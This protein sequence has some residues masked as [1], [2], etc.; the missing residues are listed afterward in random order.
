MSATASQI[1]NLTIVYSIVHSDTDQRK[2]QSSAS[3][4]FV[5]GIHRGPVNSPHKWPVT[6]K[7]FSFDDVIMAIQIWWTS[8]IVV[9]KLLAIRSHQTFVHATTGHWSCHVQ[10]FES[11]A[12]S[13]F[14]SEKIQTKFPLNLNCYGKPV[15][16]MN[17][18][19]WYQTT[20]Q[21]TWSN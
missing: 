21:T 7:M 13:K 12:F 9:I 4:A 5:R 14:E 19:D 8:R 1:T 3:L 10:N 20:Y 2:H 17:K 11:S 18:T 15:S 6:R 16:E